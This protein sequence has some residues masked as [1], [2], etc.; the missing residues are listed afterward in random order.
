MAISFRVHA[1][2][3]SGE[4]QPPKAEA[5][6]GEVF[7]FLIVGPRI[8]PQSVDHARQ[9]FYREAKPEKPQFRMLFVNHFQQFFCVPVFRDLSIECL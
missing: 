5:F 6:E 4:K 3:P 7:G 1:P 2:A 8:T 9:A